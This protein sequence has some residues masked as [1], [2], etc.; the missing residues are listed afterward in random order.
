MQ[1]KYEQLKRVRSIDSTIGL[2]YLNNNQA[3]YLKIL[4]N[5]LER[6]RALQLS[7]LSILES[8]DVIHTI[9]GLSATLGMRNLAKISKEID[10]AK[11]ENYEEFELELRLVLRELEVLFR[12]ERQLKTVLILN[13]Q[14]HQIDC[15]VNILEEYCD[16]LV[17]LDIDEADELI[18]GERVDLVLLSLDLNN[19]DSLDKLKEHFRY[20]N[21][22]TIL[23]TNSEREEGDEKFLIITHL[24]CTTLPE[25]IEK[26]LML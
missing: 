10:E 21:I 20:T 15:L 8:K 14:E 19:Q 16:L 12:E 1:L 26:R 7:R 22:P 18:D 11:T 5:F 25:I 4:N 6:Y 17:A 23:T 9:K 2:K 13:D 3:L 24:D